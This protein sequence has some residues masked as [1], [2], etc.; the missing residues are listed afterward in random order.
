MED[1]EDMEEVHFQ[2][3]IL[4]KWIDQL[5]MQQDGLQKIWLLTGFVK[6]V[7]SK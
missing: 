5:P 3:R 4:L 6:D 2:E 1:G 7:W